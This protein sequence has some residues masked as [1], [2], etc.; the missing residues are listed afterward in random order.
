MNSRLWRTGWMVL[1]AV[2]GCQKEA[3]PPEPAAL[4]PLP[5]SRAVQLVPETEQS[6]H[7]AAVNRQLDLGGTLYGY[8]DIDGDSMKFATSLRKL[9]DQIV[10]KQP[11]LGMYL[12][13]DYAALFNE[14]G[15]NDV[16]AIGFSS[17]AQAAGGFR[18]R[19][20]FYTPDGRHGLLAAV[21]GPPAAFLNTNLAPE[22]ADFYS[23]CEVDLPVAYAAVRSAIAKMG[24][25][26]V[27][28][29]FENQL[30]ITGAQTG[31]SALEL[32]QGMKGRITSVICLDP[33]RNITLPGSVPAKIPAF[34]MFFDFD[35]IGQAI[36]GALARSPLFASS[37]EGAVHYYTL[38]IP[39]PVEGLQPVLAV[40]GSTL[41]FATTK[42]FL[43]ECLHRQTGLDKNP[44]FQSALAV[45]GSEG[46]SL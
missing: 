23:E 21:G 12:D 25:E 28:D 15:F 38:I 46:N 44:K 24:G 7:F 11:K 34:S 19:T 45:A 31:L 5:M 36:E 20:F 13:H 29:L 1:L 30:R 17:V 27:A 8:V 42:P 26:S 37:M 3:K 33:K 35:G 32:I 22:E 39:L 9:T 4:P 18:N 10:A 6:R 41:Y 40:E 14:L 43:D 16:K 2:A